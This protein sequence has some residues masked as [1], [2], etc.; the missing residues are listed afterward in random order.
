MF[1]IPG[2][3]QFSVYHTAFNIGRFRS[4]R[5]RSTSFRPSQGKSCPDF[6]LEIVVREAIA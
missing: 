3:T 5:K 2:T 4:N 1:P 6:G